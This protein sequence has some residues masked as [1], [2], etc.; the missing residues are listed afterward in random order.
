MNDSSLVTYTRQAYIGNYTPNR[1]AQGGGIKKITI[2]HMAGM[3]SVQELGAL[4]ATPGRQGSSHYGVNGAGIG[5][6]V[7]ESDVAWTDSSW[8]SNITSVTIETANSATGGDW[9]VSDASLQTLCRL[10]AD[11]AKRNGLGTLVPGKNLTWHSMYF[12]T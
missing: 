10:V 12:A 3:L 9:P 5:Q 1:A 7:N 11:I 6:Y 4:W 2:H 8:T